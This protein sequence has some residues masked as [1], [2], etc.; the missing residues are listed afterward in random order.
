MIGTRELSAPFSPA[1]TMQPIGSIDYL[2]K[3]YSKGQ[4]ALKDVSL[5]IQSGEILALLGP[6]GAGRNHRWCNINS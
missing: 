5:D 2:S 1:N 4:H 3:T 6:N